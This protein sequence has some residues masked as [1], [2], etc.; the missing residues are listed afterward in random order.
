VSLHHGSGGDGLGTRFASS[1]GKHVALV[2]WLCSW[3][4]EPGAQL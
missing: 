2:Q 1:N 4:V 3:V